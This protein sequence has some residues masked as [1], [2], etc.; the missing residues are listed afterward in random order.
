VRLVVAATAEVAIPTLEWLKKSDHEL[1]RVVTTPDSRVG[2]GKVLAESAISRWADSNSIIRLKPSSE[3]ELCQAFEDTDLVIAIAYGRILT[4]RVLSIPKF[5]FINLHFSLLP[6]Y[7]G[8]APVQRAIQNGEVTTGISIFRID[9]GLDTGPVYLQ[10]KY[11]ISPSATSSDVLR[12][13]SE[14]GA[15]AF[16]RVLQD[17]EKGIQPLAQGSKSIS[18]APKIS[19]QEARINWN[20]NAKLISDSVRA[21][22]PSPGAWT[23]Y[24]ALILKI[25]AVGPALSPISLKPGEVHISGKRIFVGTLDSPLEILRI[26]PAGK[27]EMT[28]TDWLNGAR[29]VDGD[30]FE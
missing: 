20:T 19:K 28:T 18:T 26:T 9:A 11:E 5:G 25:G 1:L 21:F 4:E 15:Q 12:D 13:L 29:V 17:I 6:A 16:P 3:D 30:F 23:T 8:A 7:R 27:K 2:R 24:K 14:I 22:F 10:E